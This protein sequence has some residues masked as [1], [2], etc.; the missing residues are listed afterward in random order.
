MHLAHAGFGESQRVA[1]LFHRQL[2]VVVEDD[3]ESLVAVQALRDELHHVALLNAVGRVFALLVFEDVDLADIF[4][5][6]GLVPLLVEADEIHRTGFRLQAVVFLGRDLQLGGNVRVGG[7]IAEF[8]LGLLASGFQLARFAANQSRHPVHRAEFV[9][10][11]ATNTRHAVS[12]KLHAALHV[13]RFDR[14][15]Q[16]EHAGGDQVIQ[17]DAVGQ[18]R[19][20]PFGVVADQRQ[21]ALHQ[22]VAKLLILLVL[23]V[24][25]PNLGELFFRE[26]HKS[27]DKPLRGL[28]QIHTVR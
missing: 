5:A 14:V 12:F 10:H 19:P 7:G 6:V 28:F 16:A 24:V 18:L 4:V 3:D 9:E 25:D 26:L 2:F 23:L 27:H 17:I 8:H 15:H 1:D 22:R 21:V 13:E 20:D 11:R